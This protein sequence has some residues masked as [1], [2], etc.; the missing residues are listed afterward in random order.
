MTTP[1]NVL[2]D[3]FEE[4]HDAASANT[5]CTAIYLMPYQLRPDP[6]QV[7]FRS[8]HSPWT[9]ND[10]NIISAVFSRFSGGLR[11][12]SV[13]SVCELDPPLR[14]VVELTRST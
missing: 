4:V 1:V 2:S 10:S 8:T 6:F 13:L 14:R 7:V 9:L 12:G 11:G 3:T 5:A